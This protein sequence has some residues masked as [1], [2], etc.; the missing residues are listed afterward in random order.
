MYIYKFKIYINFVTVHCTVHL[1]VY[2]CGT[3]RVSLSHSQRSTSM[4]APDFLAFKKA[5][6]TE[7]FSPKHSTP[8]SAFV[9]CNGRMFM[10]NNE[11][12]VCNV[13]WSFLIFLISDLCF[14][15]AHVCCE[16]EYRY[17]DDAQLHRTLD[18]ETC[19]CFNLVNLMYHAPLPFFWNDNIW[20]RFE[21]A[22][23]LR[24]IFVWSTFRW[25]N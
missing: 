18:G 6:S 4:T 14:S 9:G 12:N 15:N 22:A 19:C 13:C 10:G 2:S 17:R 20:I 5:R 21:D 1:P 24:L 16:W 8:P 25:L 23:K 3:Y 11:F 7:F